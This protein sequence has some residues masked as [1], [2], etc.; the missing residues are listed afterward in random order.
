VQQAQTQIG[1]GEN[2]ITAAQNNALTEALQAYL[3]ADMPVEDAMRAIARA[4][5]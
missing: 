5:R 3:K 4:L 1:N 2:Y